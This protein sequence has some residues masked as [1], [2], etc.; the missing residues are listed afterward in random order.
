MADQNPVVIARRAGERLVEAFAAG[1]ALGALAV[2]LARRRT[3]GS[4]SERRIS[5][6][7]G[8]SERSMCRSGFQRSE[9]ISAFEHCVYASSISTRI[10]SF[11]T[12][13]STS[14]VGEQLAS[15]VMTRAAVDAERV[16]DAGDEEE[17]PD[18]R[19]G[20]EVRQRVG[21]PVARAV[22]DQQRALVEDADE[23]GRVAA[24]RDVEAAVR[25]ARSRGT[26]NG[27][28]STNWRVRSF[29]RSAIFDDDELRAARR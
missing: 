22:G 18:A 1:V 27:E 24:R 23:A 2:V 20:E 4:L 17:Q 28:R 13:P 11:G 16:A 5:P 21:E 9:R 14:L 15:S 25:A 7:L 29:R 12:L 19:V 3:S 26:T 6:E 8:S 10:P